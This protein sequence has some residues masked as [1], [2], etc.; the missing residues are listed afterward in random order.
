MSPDYALVP[1]KTADAFTEE[2]IKTLE[3]FYP[4]SSARSF[5]K[6]ETSTRIRNETDFTRFETVLDAAD[7]DGKVAYRGEADKSTNRMGISIIRLDK[8]SEEKSWLVKDEIF[9]PILLVIP[10]DDIDSAIAYINAGETP[11]ALYVSS[12][13]RATFEYVVDRTLSGSAIWND[14]AL[15][16]VARTV[17]FGGV[18]ESGW[19]SYHGYDGFLTFS[20]SKSESTCATRIPMLTL[21]PSHPRGALLARVRAEEPLRPQRVGG[22]AAHAPPGHVHWHQ[23]QAPC[24]RGR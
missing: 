18:G 13:T 23:L 8:P 3:E 22:L 20:H 21:P 5:L 11:L 10:Y 16:P 19:G 9:G 7:K 2:L 1:R 14:F 15:T 4:P 12:A 24:Q 6:E 17:P